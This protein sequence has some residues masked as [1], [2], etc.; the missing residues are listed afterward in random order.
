VAS[1]GDVADAQ[2]FLRERIV[3]VDA[4]SDAQQALLH[5]NLEIRQQIAAECELLAGRLAGP[6]E[7]HER[8][9]VLALAETISD[10][11]G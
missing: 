3:V 11:T 1:A 10:F 5:K 9:R 2:D 7:D 4:R 8:R 6:L